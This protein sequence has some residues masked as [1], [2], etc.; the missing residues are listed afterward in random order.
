MTRG[1][2]SIAFLVCVPRSGSTMLQHILGSHPFVHT[3]PEPWF[4]LPLLYAPRETGWSAEYNAQYAARALAGF[5]SRLPDGAASWYRA[6]QRLALSLYGDALDATG[7]RIFLDK[8]PRYYLIIPELLRTFPTAKF[9]FL[10]R[11]PLAIF[12]SILETNFRGNLRGF[13]NTDRIVDVIKGPDLVAKGA[14]LANDRGILVRYEDIVSAPETGVTRICTHLG[15]DFRPEMLQYGER[16]HF[17][18]TTFVDPKSVYKHDSP[19]TTY[20]NRWV[21]VYSTPQLNSIARQYLERLGD[22]TI[23]AFG[24]DSTAL[25]DT[26]NSVPLRAKNHWQRLPLALDSLL[27][28]RSDMSIQQRVTVDTLAFLGAGGL[29]GLVSALRTKLVGK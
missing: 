3:V 29:P 1:S 5:L 21:D 19:V 28:P 7:K 23:R 15:I 8:T 9:I 13:S 17:E 27:T 25:L 11:N 16:I 26:L 4:L 12:A 24:Y 2:E 10:T 14:R 22:D 20:V 6:V 18:G